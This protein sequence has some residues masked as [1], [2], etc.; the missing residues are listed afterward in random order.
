MSSRF[1]ARHPVGLYLLCAVELCERF[2][3][4]LL[5]SLLLLYLNER[6]GMAS[7]AAMR[8][9]GAFNAVVY[10][11]SVP[12]GIFADRF[13]GARRAILLGAAL[14]AVGYAVLSTDQAPALYPAAFL[15]IVGHALFKPNISAAVGKLY[16]RADHRRDHAYSIFYVICNVGAALGPLAGGSLRS[17]YGWPTAFGA[18]AL[19]MFCAFAAGVIGYRILTPIDPRIGAEDRSRMEAPSPQAWPVAAMAGL[20]L[21]VLLFTA[22]YEQSG[23][24]LLFWVRDCAHRSLFGHTLPPSTLLA[25]PGVLVLALQPLLSRLLSA[26]AGRGREPTHLARIL[27]GLLCSVG[28]YV[29]MV[30]A[31]VLH[32]QRPSTISIWWLVGCFL[33]LTLGELLVYPV[34]LSLVTRMAPPSLTAAAA[35]IWMAAIAVGQWLAGEVAARWAIW[36]HATFFAAVATLALSAVAVLALTARRIHRALSDE[37][38]GRHAAPATHQPLPPASPHLSRKCDSVRASIDAVST[39]L[40]IAKV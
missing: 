16:E 29:L 8:V 33:A 24:S 40:S 3:G 9:A 22:T 30:A 13:I 15:L 19:A 5:G 23:Q 32:G 6:L 21:A 37:E 27:T 4:T 17:V 7:G 1:G 12:G 14:L 18:A 25:V 36:S 2:A 34:S 10:A 31:T 35:G 26:L 39:H 11:S 28:A 20:L 38:K